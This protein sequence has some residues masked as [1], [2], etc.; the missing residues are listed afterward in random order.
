MLQIIDTFPVFQNLF[1][2][3]FMFILFSDISNSSRVDRGA[4][5]K[6]YDQD[7]VFEPG[8]V[9]FSIFRSDLFSAPTIVKYIYFVSKGK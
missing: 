8:W 2:N 3:F 6:S 7:R 5:H 9:L 1:L 4:A